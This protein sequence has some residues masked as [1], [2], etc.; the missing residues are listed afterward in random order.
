VS[1]F[2][3]GNTVLYCS[4][5]KD[6]RNNNKPFRCILCFRGMSAAV[7]S[8]TLLRGRFSLVHD[9]SLISVAGYQTY[10]CAE[11]LGITEAKFARTSEST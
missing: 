1:G 5:C 3:N 2:A 10:Y 8:C 4:F 11:P 7:Q 6:C 9:G